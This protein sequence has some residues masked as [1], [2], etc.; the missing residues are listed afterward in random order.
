MINIKASNNLTLADCLGGYISQQDFPIWQPIVTQDGI[1][2]LYIDSFRIPG[3]LD[4]AKSEFTI[5]KTGDDFALS[6]TYPIVD[7]WTTL[8]HSFTLAVDETF[9]STYELGNIKI[10]RVLTGQDGVMVGR[11]GIPYNT[12][13]GGDNVDAADTLTRYGCM[14]LVVEDDTYIEE[15]IS[16]GIIDGVDTD[17]ACQIVLF[18]PTI[19]VEAIATNLIEPPVPYWLNTL[20]VG[21]TV[22]AGTYPLWFKT[23]SSGA[24]GEVTFVIE[25][26]QAVGGALEKIAILGKH[27]RYDETMDAFTLYGAYNGDLI[28]G[29]LIDTFSDFPALVMLELPGAGNRNYLLRVTS[30]NKYGIESQNVLLEHAVSISSTGADVTVPQTPTNV[31]LTFVGNGYGML[32]FDYVQ[33]TKSKVIYAQ[34]EIGTET[35]LGIPI[36]GF[37][38]YSVRGYIPILWGEEITAKVRFVDNLGRLGEWETDIETAIFTPATMPLKAIAKPGGIYSTPGNH[39]LYRS[40]RSALAELVTEPSRVSFYYD[41]ALEF[42]IQPDENSILTLY[43][44]AYTLVEDAVSGAQVDV[45]EDDSGVVYV[46]DGATRRIAIDTDAKTITAVKF[47]TLSLVAHRQEPIITISGIVCFQAFPTTMNGMNSPET[48]MAMAGEIVYLCAYV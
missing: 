17:A 27:R 30:K 31:A 45:I 35:T 23:V 12:P 1:R 39:S 18:N 37:G 7:G 26:D 6:I 2:C 46:S 20:P 11:I 25:I 24:I 10:R 8:S 48:W 29:S 33:D 4:A 16:Y 34:V 44:G 41:G 15:I 14:F 38:T 5:T 42:Y 40:D 47:L 21:F 22:P 28:D 19:Q 36:S 9:Q 43:L 3:G 13:L 32:E